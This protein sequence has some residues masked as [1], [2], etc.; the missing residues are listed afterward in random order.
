[1]PK[2]NGKSLNTL[3]MLIWDEITGFYRSKVMVF[4][5]FGMPVISIL[6]LILNPDTEGIPIL[7][8]VSLI[9][10]SLGGT[11]GSVMLATSIVNEKTHHV[12]DLFVIRKEN[13][14][15]SLILAKF[16][17]VYLCLIVTVFLSL[18][19]GVSID[20]FR[21]ISASDLLLEDLFDSLWISMSAMAIACSLGILIGLL[22]KSVPVA[23]ILSIY[24]GNQVSMISVIPGLLIEEIDAVSFAISAG[25]IITIT[26]MIINMF[27]IKKLQL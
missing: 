24:V 16:I 13:I 4:L 25:L 15:G 21:G 12:Y 23:A 18:V 5:L 8:F 2:K 17:S 6:M 20:K 26:A 1:M 9:V 22:M 10:S 7:L 11:L 3:L 19:I 27:L 14:R